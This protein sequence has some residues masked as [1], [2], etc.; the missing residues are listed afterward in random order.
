MTEPEEPTRRRI[1]VARPG[2]WAEVVDR[3]AWAASDIEA[4][5]TFLAP[6]CGAPP[7]SGCGI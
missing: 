5:N 7:I 6:H 3:E 2:A 4:L 1:V